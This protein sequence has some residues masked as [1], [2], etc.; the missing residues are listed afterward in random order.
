MQGHVRSCARISERDDRASLLALMAALDASPLAL[1]RDLSRGEGRK[2]D[3]WGAIK[4]KLSFC[5]LRQDGD[6][7]GCLHLDH[8]PTACQ[9]EAIRD[10]LHIRKRRHMTPEAAA[11]ARSALE[12]AGRRV[13]STPGGPGSFFPVGRHAPSGYAHSEGIR[14]VLPLPDSNLASPYQGRGQRP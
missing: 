2:G 1:Q 3:R 7:E 13:K 12:R 10:A 6:D 8:L 5:Q 4:D 11:K 9:A 14:A